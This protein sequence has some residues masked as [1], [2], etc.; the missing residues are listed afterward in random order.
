MWLQR[1]AVA[2]DENHAT[3]QAVLMCDV[4]RMPRRSTGTAVRA[5]WLWARPDGYG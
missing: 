5:V 2:H 3:R 4:R 1:R